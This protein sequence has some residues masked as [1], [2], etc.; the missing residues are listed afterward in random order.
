MV[1]RLVATAQS[2]L[3]VQIIVTKEGTTSL[4]RDIPRRLHDLDHPGV[5]QSQ[6]ENVLPQT[7][8]M[9]VDRFQI[10]LR[11][12]GENCGHGCCVREL[13]DDFYGKQLPSEEVIVGLK[14][15]GVKEEKREGWEVWYTHRNHRQ[16]HIEDLRVSNGQ[17]ARYGTDRS[18]CSW[19]NV[20]IDAEAALEEG[21][22]DRKHQRRSCLQILVGLCRR[23]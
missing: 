4:R 3:F 6:R 11:S 19:W 23:E 13:L 15:H 9:L 22:V 7:M 1:V 8:V 10:S 17:A 2:H 20:E 12:S 14:A 21:A 5:I 18:R 16:V